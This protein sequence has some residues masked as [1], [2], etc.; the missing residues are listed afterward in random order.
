MTAFQ[1]A[2]I[3]YLVLAGLFVFA[4]CRAAARGDAMDE[5]AMRM[6]E[7]RTPAE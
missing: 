4:L 7:K 1:I 2:A 5:D 6:N 3:I